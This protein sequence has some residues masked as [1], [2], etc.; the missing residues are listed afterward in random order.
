MPETK[1]ELQDMKQ[2]P[3][4]E[5]LG[6]LMWL[7]VATHP[8]LSYAV[9]TLSRFANNPGR[10]HWNAMKHTLAYLKGTLNYG[11]SYHRGSSLKPHGYVDADYAGDTDRHR[12]TEGHIFFVTQGPVSWASK[13][14]GTVALLTVE[15]EF[16]AFTRAIQQAIWMMKFMNEIGL[17]QA[18]PVNIFADNTGAIANT[19]NY[20]NHNWTKHIDIRYHFTKERVAPG[21]VKFTYVPSS[22]NLA[23][24]LT[25]PLA[26][27]AILRCCRGIGLLHESPWSKQG[28]Y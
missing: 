10:A 21:E 3:Y 14:Q 8:D 26:K 25:K 19:E 22:N 28:E 7:Q 15:A 20:K 6:S 23:D 11:I 17:G 2:V 5:A 27:E 1:E 16:M 9:N 4:C 18:T 24:I 12:S 13:R